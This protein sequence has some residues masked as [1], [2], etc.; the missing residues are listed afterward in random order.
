MKMLMTVMMM[1]TVMT[2]DK[3]NIIFKG[4]ILR[5]DMLMVASNNI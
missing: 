1:T 5:L 4:R 3:N 2:V